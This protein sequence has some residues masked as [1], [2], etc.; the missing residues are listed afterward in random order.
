MIREPTPQTLSVCDES[1][2]SYAYGRPV[3]GTGLKRNSTNLPESSWAAHM[4]RAMISVQ[5]DIDAFAVVEVHG[6]RLRS[7]VDELKDRGYSDIVTID[8]VE[9]ED[10][11][12]RRL[13]NLLDEGNPYQFCRAA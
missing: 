12:A 5:Y 4:A 2:G 6:Q 1:R 7:R 13:G 9:R 11:L 10:E 3:A 8:L